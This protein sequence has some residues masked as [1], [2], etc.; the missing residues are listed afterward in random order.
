MSTHT[1]TPWVWD[2]SRGVVY[3]CLRSGKRIAMMIGAVLAEED[4]ATFIV[5]ACNAHDDLITALKAMVAY[6]DTGPESHV[7][8]MLTYDNAMK[9]A[10][11]ALAKAAA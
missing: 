11:A 4:D 3:I 10:R 1:P 8:F 2:K 9:L 6:D 5:S 7:D